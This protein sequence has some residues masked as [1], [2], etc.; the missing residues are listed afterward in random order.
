MIVAPGMKTGVVPPSSAELVPASSENVTL[1]EP[2]GITGAGLSCQP[3]SKFTMSPRAR[4]SPNRPIT[5]SP[6]SRRSNRLFMS[7]VL[8]KRGRGVMRQRGRIGGARRSL[9][10]SACQVKRNAPLD[11]TCND[12][13]GLLSP[14]GGHWTRSHS[15]HG[16][17]RMAK[18]RSRL[19]DYAAYVAVRVA[20][21][22]V[23]VLSWSRALGFAEF[24]GW[25]A[26]ALDR[27]HRLVA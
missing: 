9:M 20:V 2:E 4:L 13:R 26:H 16:S 23:Q 5:V 18:P 3:K 27:R 22:L 10:E 1:P 8:R 14:A 12:S 19:A 24:L 6:K 7:R 17:A 21:A 25:L 11:R 15:A